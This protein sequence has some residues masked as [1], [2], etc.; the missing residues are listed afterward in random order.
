MPIITTQTVQGSLSGYKTEFVSSRG[1]A[2]VCDVRPS[3]M[4]S[5]STALTAADYRNIQDG[6]VVYVTTTRFP[7][8]LS[9][10]LPGI[11]VQF[12]LVTGD[13]DIA[14]PGGLW[15]TRAMP[16][17]AASLISDPR[18]K[19]WFAQNCDIDHPKVTPVPIGLDYHTLAECRGGHRWGPSGT[20]AQQEAELKE[21]ISSM[22]VL[23]DRPLLCL[24][25][26]HFSLFG[27]RHKC[28]R[29]LR[30]KPFVVFQKEFLPRGKTWKAH[31]GCSFVASPPGN[32]VDCHR[33]WEAMVLNTIPIVRRN[34]LQALF[35]DLP[36]MLVDDWNEVDEAALLRF[37]QS[38]E[39]STFN[40][41]KLTLD[42]WAREFR[43]AAESR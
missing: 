4:Q 18:L 12:V 10:I 26:F 41:R 35:H 25:N 43:A 17:P 23:G 16:I 42:Y 31:A 32:G 1:I 24:A 33:T 29:A 30:G 38:I 6:Q 11:D 13:S 5:D 2:A 36:V 22:P 39:T 28:L 3:S 9:E 21:I 37:K 8:F 14:A 20:P 27:E 19:H 15:A 7:D 34:S 40:T